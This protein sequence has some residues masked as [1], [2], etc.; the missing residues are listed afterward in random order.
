LLA[1]AVC[2]PLRLVDRSIHFGGKSFLLAVEVEDEAANGMLPTKL[3]A[4]QA[5]VSQGRPEKAF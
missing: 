1:L 3:A 2:L 5:S 4:G